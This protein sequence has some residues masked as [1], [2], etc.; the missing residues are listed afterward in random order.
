MFDMLLKIRQS[1]SELDL[2]TV[3]AISRSVPTVTALKTNPAVSPDSLGMV[4]TEEPAHAADLPSEPNSSEEKAPSEPNS[5]GE[6]APSEPNSVGEAIRGAGSGGRRELR[7]DAP[8]LELEPG[9]I[10]F[11][12]NGAHSP[13]F[14]GVL[15]GRKQPFLDLTPIFGQR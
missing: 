13:A 1:G 7:A 10:G 9:A 5:V 6:K 12:G 15:S 4:P 14:K 8:H 3:H 11:T 2:A